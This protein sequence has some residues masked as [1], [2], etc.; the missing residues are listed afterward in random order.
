M[1]AKHT[2]LILTA[3]FLLIPTMSW[4]QFPGGGGFGGGGPGGFG[5]GAPGGTFG[6]GGMRRF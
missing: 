5:G 3:G 6:G 1:R 4:S 2:A